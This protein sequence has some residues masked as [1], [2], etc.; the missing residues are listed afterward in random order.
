[1]AGGASGSRG[2]EPRGDMVW[3]GPANRCGAEKSRL[4][5]SIAICRI[6]GVVVVDM[7]G[8][9]GRGRRRHMRAGQG[10]PSRAMVEGRCI[11]T[12]RRVTHRAI[13]CR[14]SRPGG[15][16][17]RIVRLL[18][19]GQMALGIPAI[20]G[21]NRQSVVVVD[22]AGGAGHVGMAVG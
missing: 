18:P 11:P 17:H 14:E 19:G 6:E 16:M 8:S 4:M 12:H 5:A 21:S 20:G 9:A 7:A 2:R 15:G 22:V 1:M 13:R 3:H 10:K